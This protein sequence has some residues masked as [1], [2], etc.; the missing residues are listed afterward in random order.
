MSETSEITGPLLKM[1]NQ[2]GF[3][4]WLSLFSLGLKRVVPR[5]QFRDSVPTLAVIVAGE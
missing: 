2:E 4:L 5:L 1:L 3:R